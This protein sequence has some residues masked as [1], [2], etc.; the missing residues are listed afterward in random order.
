MIDKNDKNN[1]IDKIKLHGF[2]NFVNFAQFYLILSILF[3]T[4]Y[5]QLSK[6]IRCIFKPEDYR[7]FR[8]PPCYL[9][10]FALWVHWVFEYRFEFFGN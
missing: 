3:N 1:K 7:L 4:R 2:Y 6:Y 5:G 8:N 9:P 10:I